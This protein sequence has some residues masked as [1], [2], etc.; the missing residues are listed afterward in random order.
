MANT[1]T[2]KQK[3]LQLDPGTFQNLCD[4]YLSK[5]GYSDIVSLGSKAGTKKTTRGTPDS[6]FMTADGKYVFAEYT[7]KITGLY[8]KVMGDLEKCLN[9]TTTGISHNKISEIVY[10]H[11]SSNLTPSQNEAAMK[12][13]RDVGIHLVMIGIDKIATDLCQSY[14]ILARDYLGIAVDT[15][16]IFE[17]DD[18]ITHHNSNKISAPIT[19]VCLF[20][21]AEINTLNEAY[22]NGKI[23]VLSGAAGTGK[24]QL[25]LTYGKEHSKICG[26][27][28]LV[29]RSNAL[30]LYEDLKLF[31][32]S[33]GDY[34]LV[35]DDANEIS[36]LR[37]IIQYAMLEDQGYNVKI[38][39]TVRD[40]AKRKVI[41]VL[42]DTVAYQKIDLKPFTDDKIK[43]LLETSLGILNQ[44][45]Q[46]RIV[47]IAEGNARIAILAGQIAR[48][49]N[50]IDSINDISQ[51]Y[52]AY[53]TPILEKQQLLN[54]KRLCISAGLIA[55][56][57]TIRLD[58]LDPFLPILEENE[59]TKE[60]FSTCIQALNELEIVDIY[61]EKGVRISDQS[62]SNYLLKVVFYDRKLLKLS[63]LI[64]HFFEN[65]REKTIYSINTLISIFNNPELHDFV[66]NEVLIMW[67]VFSKE[68]SSLF[69]DFI[70]A[71]YQV[72]PI[73][74]LKNIRNY[75]D[76]EPLTDVSI[77]TFDF[78]KGRNNNHISDNVL[79]ILSGFAELPELK[80]ALDLL[81]Q[82]Y[83]K[84]P[85][86][87]MQFFHAIVNGFG[88]HRHTHLNEYHVQK[89]LLEKFEE[90][91]D[92][93]SRDCI[94]LLY[95]EVAEEL[96]KFNFSSVEE[97]RN[98]KVT[99]YEFPLV[100]SSGAAEYRGII[101]QSLSVLAT[102]DKY[103]G[104]IRKL[105]L[106]YGVVEEAS[107]SVLESDLSYIVKI[108][109]LEFPPSQIQNCIVV[110]KLA[111][112]FSHLN[113]IT[114]ATFD[115]YL[116]QEQFQLY[117]L[118]KGESDSLE[119]SYQDQE[120]ITKDLIEKHLADSD[121]NIFKKLIDVS[122]DVEDVIDG[123]EAWEIS[124]GLKIAFDVIP[125]E[126]NYFVE[127]VEYYL[128]SNAPLNLNPNLFLNTLFTLLPENK[129]HQL[130]TIFDYDHKNSWLYAYFHEL[131][132]NIITEVHL[133][134]L[135]A[136]LADDSDR[137]IKSSSLRDVTFL[138]KY[139]TYDEEV[140]TKGCDL[141]LQ[142]YKYSPFVA[143]L[144]L[145][146]LISQ[147][148]ESPKSV[149]DKF[150]GHFDLLTNIYFSELQYDKI[151]DYKGTLLKELFTA[152]P[153]ILD[154]YIEFL[155]AR[156]GY[157]SN[158]YEERH[159][160]FY[161]LD[162]FVET[163]NV[164]FDKLIQAFPTH[165]YYV[166]HY[167]ETVL[168]PN[169]DTPLLAE[170]QDAWIRQCIQL[171]SHEDTKMYCLFS[172]LSKME[173]S[174]KVSYYS[175]FIECNSSFEDFEKLPIIP[176][177]Y[178]YSGSAVPLYYEWIES[179]ELLLPQF[180]GIKWIDHKSFIIEMIGNL[181]K[182]I[183][184]EEIREIM[185]G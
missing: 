2:I 66:K 179:L 153:S 45:Y 149:I 49:K 34:F 173:I 143:S 86:L 5:I 159:L 130:V 150:I 1:E 141:I 107:Y 116:K 96:L 10:C 16:Q 71:F 117:C 151:V 50:R 20:R 88:I 17:Y 21:E 35:V 168:S 41:S 133:S 155:I 37:H 154:R 23:V 101:W 137:T 156:N 67:E 103:K 177:F 46:E 42:H 110:E 28:L 44:D 99:F 40:Y 59:I 62:F 100:Y 134:R 72:N 98:H 118:L 76:H 146:S 19:N 97:E 22:I 161:Y 14:P 113:S 157:V 183:E 158:D 148:H 74:A 125:Q 77:V 178:G 25:A 56:L 83:L 104:R 170:K 48:E 15:N 111:S 180:I 139:K 109:K 31:L 87:Y 124:R 126:N 78:Q 63:T 53:Y 13:C 122:K 69:L 30:S 55:F 142:K 174:R 57:Q 24:T 131:P 138:E 92:N 172:V 60:C 169:K 4:A 8:E 7:T 145:S 171:F 121:I 163:Y 165:I 152:N 68:K 75:I 162:N 119:L 29:I 105:L 3:I 73:T 184:E 123:H 70:K 89:T 129:V 38:L 147:D 11:T 108:L 65:Y 36:E 82:Y 12:R 6:Y 32:S 81:F 79:E 43:G 52:D 112:V 128:E 9:E 80:S 167:L 182:S 144:Y 39:M 176:N 95:L 140:F 33:P 91:S 93:W 64:K 54:E 26:E 166:P 132:V 102:K 127:A 164:I 47:R 51:L 185:R 135:Y 27:K 58:Y 160:C 120:K 114:E 136:F 85:D 106:S 61:N 175:L 181:K 84:H 115:D 90:Y 94:N 18:F